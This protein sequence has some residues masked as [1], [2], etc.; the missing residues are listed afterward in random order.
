M[1][2]FG[3]RFD[4]STFA[5][6]F[7]SIFMLLA[8]VARATEASKA[9]LEELFIWKMSDELSLVPDE[10]KKFTEKIKNLNQ[11]KSDLNA[12]MQD[13][14]QSMQKAKT[15]AEKNKKLLKY[16]KYLQAYNRLSEEEFDAMKSLLGAKR[17]V[18]YLEVKQDL[19]NRLKSL[20]AN[21][22]SAPAP[23][24]SSTPLP[25]PRIIEE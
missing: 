3:L 18:K 20:L 23:K 21:P 17:L 25:S 24:K 1:R 10:E 13:L 6:T 15:D 16:K 5:I 8:P 9:K 22:D 19:T 14:M 11:K 4:N 12:Q 2:G 7:I